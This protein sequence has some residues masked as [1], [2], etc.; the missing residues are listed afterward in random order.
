MDYVET[1]LLLS[2]LI[3]N[4]ANNRLARAILEK[5]N[6]PVTSELTILEATA[7][8]SRIIEHIELPEEI[9]LQ[10]VERPEV[11]VDGLVMYA[12]RRENIRVV[13][14]EHYTLSVH[15]IRTLKIVKRAMEIAKTLR[16]KT[17][18]LLHI[19]YA[20][21]MGADRILTLDKE[22]AKKGKMIRKLTGIEV[23]YDVRQ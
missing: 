20:E 7:V 17:L 22:M 10:V 11:A 8:L 4:D 21:E 5:A 23:V 6:D 12:I 2:S 1:S 9:M 13:E 14:I 18:D 3:E 16:L 19:V 15:G